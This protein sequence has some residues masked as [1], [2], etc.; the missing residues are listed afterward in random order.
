MKGRDLTTTE[1]LH[2]S[3]LNDPAYRAEWER[4]HLAHEVA[5]RVIAYRV[6]HHLTQMELARK[7]GMR[8]RHIARLE[9][10][11]HM[12]SLATLSPLARVL[13]M[14]LPL[15]ITPRGRV[16]EASRGAS[17]W[18]DSREVAGKC[19]EMFGSFTT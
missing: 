13:G 5:Q 9:A 19:P 7:L 1:V 10:G 12:P 3:S 18:P 2:A 8:Q 4:T 14:A 16:S 15:D 17:R 6:E 11:E